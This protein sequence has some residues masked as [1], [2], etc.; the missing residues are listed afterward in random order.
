[1]NSLHAKLDSQLARPPASPWTLSRFPRISLYNP[2]LLNGHAHSVLVVHHI[3]TLVISRGY[4]E[5]VQL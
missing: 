2:R 5:F 1:M 3:E 4:T